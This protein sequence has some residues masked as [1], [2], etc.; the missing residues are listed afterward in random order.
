M[1]PTCATALAAIRARNGRRSGGGVGRALSLKALL[2][3]TRRALFQSLGLDDARLCHPSGVVDRFVATTPDGRRLDVC[4]D[5][6]AVGVPLLFQ[7]GTP[8]SGQLFAP[9]VTAAAERGLRMV[10]FSRAGY[11]SSDRNPGRSVADVI[12]DTVAALDRLSAPRFYALGWSGGGPHALACSALLPDRLIAAA[13]VGSLAPVG[14]EGLDWLAGMGDQNVLAFRA[15]QADSTE[16]QRVLVDVAPSFA[17]ITGD[18]VAETLATLASHVDRAAI[19][20]EAADWLA[21][22]FQE[23]VRNGI[24]GWYDEELAL[25][26]PWGFEPGDIDAP[27]AIWQGTEDHF[28]PYRHGEWLAQHI[29]AARAHLLAGEGHLSLGVDSFGRI[30]DDLL[31][32][33]A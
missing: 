12:P 22:V 29:P 20:G 23:S 17:T 9:F 2:K 16:L 24:W 13:T 7:N 3:I 26:H 1:W 19:S 21:A 10:S 8:S 4:V 5:G 31:G 15:A 27:V 18:E 14:S 30:L 33:A 11:G 28:T 25:V 6:P 32:L